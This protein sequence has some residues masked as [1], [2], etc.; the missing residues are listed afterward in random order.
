[1][2]C[3]RLFNN[4]NI[5]DVINYVG[6]ENFDAVTKTNFIYSSKNAAIFVYRFETF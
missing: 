2:R 1:M 5:F 6:L 3:P 4:C